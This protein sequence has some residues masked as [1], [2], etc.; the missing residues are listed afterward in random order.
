MSVYRARKTK[1]D[2]SNPEAA[3]IKDLAIKASFALDA[4]TV[5][6]AEFI[7]WYT[8]AVG[9]APEWTQPPVNWMFNAWIAAQG[10]REWLTQ[11]DKDKREA[12]RIKMLGV[13]AKRKQTKEA[14]AVSPVDKKAAAA[15]RKRVSNKETSSPP[16]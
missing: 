8:D 10:E 13:M 3:M 2:A 11:A 12:H 9:V 14:K 1:D 4:F 6:R 16:P 15:E 7:V 5:S